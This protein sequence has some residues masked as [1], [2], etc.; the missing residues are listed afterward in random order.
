MR[1]KHRRLLGS[2]YIQA[3]QQEQLIQAVI[4]TQIHCQEAE[5]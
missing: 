5:S 2:F 1:Y 3:Q 4:K